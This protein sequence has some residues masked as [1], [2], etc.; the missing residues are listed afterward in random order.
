M[1]DVISR[2]PPWSWTASVT[3]PKGK[4]S[5]ASSAAA[6]W[7]ALARWRQPDRA[8]P[9]RRTSSTAG[10]GRKG[11]PPCSLLLRHGRT[12]A[13][14]SR[15]L[16]GRMDVPL[17]ELGRRQAEALGR[18]SWC[19]QATRV[20]SSPLRR[21]RDTAA[22][23]GRPVTVDER[24]TEIDYGIYDG[25]AAGAAPGAV[26]ASGAATS[27]SFPREASR[28]RRVGRRVR[29]GVRGPLARG[30]GRRHGGRQ[31]RVADQ[32]GRGLGARRGRRDQLADVRRRGLGV[33]HRAGSAGAGGADA[34]AAPVQRH[35]PA[36][37]CVTSPA[38]RRI[39]GQP[40]HGHPA[41]PSPGHRD[42]GPEVP[43]LAA[44]RGAAVAPGVSSV[45]PVYVD[46]ARAPSSS[47]STATPS[48]TS[49]PASR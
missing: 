23:L 45:L 37:V 34:V 3:F 30:R 19:R 38:Y 44:R 12:A 46:R 28:W 40:G 1:T 42:P 32:G 11:Q 35:P 13:N 22:A 27:V 2:C 5:P 9:V 14:A 15:R 16:L 17:D 49:D 41:A 31:P 18:S 6:S 20:V 8:P 26:A 10:K 39:H 4:W 25:L 33:L 47:T 24:W 43:A 48:S 7:C 29:A 36:P 21:A